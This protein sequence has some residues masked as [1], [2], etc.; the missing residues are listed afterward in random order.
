VRL[1]AR[2]FHCTEGH[3]Y[4]A[5]IVGAL[6]SAM[7][8]L[9][10]PPLLRADTPAA[11]ATTSSSPPRSGDG[12]DTAPS[13]PRFG[14]APSPASSV[15]IPRYGEGIGPTPTTSTSLAGP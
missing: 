8:V 2:A 9:G 1:L 11:R 10:V 4:T 14:E 15:S 7:A 3:A 13:I 6:L 5:L 12:N